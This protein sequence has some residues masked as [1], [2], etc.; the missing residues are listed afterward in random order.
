VL[1]SELVEREWYKAEATAFL[2]N[3]PYLYPYVESIVSAFI[4]RC[5]AYIIEA[6]TMD[7]FPWDKN[8][9]FNDKTVKVI[10]KLAELDSLLKKIKQ[11]K[12][13]AE[14]TNQTIQQVKQRAS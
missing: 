4:S 10:L 8:P 7:F 1:H 9:H 5:N 11:K 3:E 12:D 2:R 6:S 14:V 13:E